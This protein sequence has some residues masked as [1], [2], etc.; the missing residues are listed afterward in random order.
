ML[1]LD[2]ALKIGLLNSVE[3]AAIFTTMTKTMEER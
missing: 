3:G 2:V 1:G